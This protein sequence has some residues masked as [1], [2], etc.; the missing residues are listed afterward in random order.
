MQRIVSPDTN[1]QERIPPR[2][3]LTRKWPVLHEGPTPKVDF[4]TWDLRLFGAV[5]EPSRW[6]WDEF[7]ALPAVEVLMERFAH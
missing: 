2:Q 4:S 5:E 3:S 1:R 7:R 6:T